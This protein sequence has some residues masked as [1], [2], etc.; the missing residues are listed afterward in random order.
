MEFQFTIDGVEKTVIAEKS[1]DGYEFSIGETTYSVSAAPLSNGSFAF[2]VD[3][4]SNLAI[5]SRDERGL[6]IGLGGETYHLE[7]PDDDEESSGGHA[8]GDGNGSVQSPMPG[9]IVAVNVAGGDQVSA[10]QAVV[11]IESMK[12]QNEITASIDGTVTA[13]HCS[14]GDQ[15][16]LGDLLVEIEP[17]ES[18][19]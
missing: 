11:V 16:G 8:G 7:N 14:V 3:N 2:L 15:V 10:G 13:V 18:D 17:A 19:E 6:T 9:N 4:R 12:M 5:I 1:G